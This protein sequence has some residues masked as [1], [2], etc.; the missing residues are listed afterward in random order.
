MTKKQNILLIVDVQK[1]FETRGYDECIRYI[2]KH[3]DDYDKI[4]ATVFVNRPVENPNFK[5]KL[6]YKKCKDATSYDIEFCADQIFMKSGYAIPWGV[7]GKNDHVDVIGTEADACVL[8]T[9][10]SLWDDGVDFDILW[11]YVFGGDVDAV[12]KIA[13]KNFGV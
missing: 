1:Q 3:R 12:K 8:G 9:C 10:F 5:K 13:K 2:E 6:G 11:D 4:I 7:F